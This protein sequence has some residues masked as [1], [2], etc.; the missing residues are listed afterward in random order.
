MWR[1]EN[2]SVLTPPAADSAGQM[3][4]AGITPGGMA[5]DLAGQDAEAPEDMAAQAEA[6]AAGTEADM[7]PPAQ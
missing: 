4:T 7:A 2:G 5:A 6:G 1:E 3:R